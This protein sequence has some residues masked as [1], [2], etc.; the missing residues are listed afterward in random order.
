MEI[1]KDQLHT[2]VGFLDPAGGKRGEQVKKIRARSAIVVI[3]ADNMNR[4]FV[5]DTWADRCDVAQMRAKVYEMNK[6]WK[7]DQFGVEGNAQQSL[8]AQSMILDAAEKQEDIN[9]ISVPQ[10]T[11]ITK[12]FRIRTHIQPL[13]PDGRLFLRKEHTDLKDEIITFPMAELVDLLDA[14]ASA[15]GMIPKRISLNEENYSRDAHLEYLRNSGAP[16]SHIER[17]AAQ[18]A[19]G[20]ASGI[21]PEEFEDYFLSRQYRS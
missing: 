5:R 13:L 9:I 18:Y 16:I 4:I 7:C 14:L 19:N 15:V 1:H 2:T 12:E 17:V 10:P 6:R 8:F 21:G 11:V 3:S 20:H